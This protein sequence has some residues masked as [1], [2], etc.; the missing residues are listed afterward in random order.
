MIVFVKQCETHKAFVGADDPVR[1]EKGYEFAADLRK[2]GLFCRADRDVRPYTDLIALQGN[3][4]GL[5]LTV[6]DQ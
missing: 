5:F 3:E 6:S 1:P 2:I 4:I